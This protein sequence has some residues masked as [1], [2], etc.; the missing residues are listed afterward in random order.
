M[1]KSLLGR[2]ER[3]LAV[4]RPDYLSQ[5]QPGVRDAQL[6]KFESR[7]GIK[8]PAAF[9]EL[10]RWRNGQENHCYDS[11][12]LNRMFTPLDE[13]ADI[14]DM[15]DGMIGTDFKREGWWRRG[16]VP[17]LSNGGGSHLCLDVAAEDGGKVGQLVAFW[18]ADADRPIEYPSVKA[19]LEELVSSMED[20]SLRRVDV[21]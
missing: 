3:W 4:N 10:Y 1:V 9:R 13:V 7:F 11:L 19:W 8:L 12:Q 14:K 16:W 5:L 6:D 2:M 20:G 21:Y 15:L 17:F 18:K